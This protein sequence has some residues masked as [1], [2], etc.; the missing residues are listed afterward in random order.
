[1]LSEN[2]TQK[3]LVSLECVVVNMSLFSLTCTAQRDRIHVKHNENDKS[4]T[5]CS[6]AASYIKVRTETALRARSEAES[7]PSTSVG[8]EGE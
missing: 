5:S 7:E 6:K 4:L 3:L 8:S 1:M 2:L